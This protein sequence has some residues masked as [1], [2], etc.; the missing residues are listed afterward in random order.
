MSKRGRTKK[1]K[2]HIRST[3]EY[4]QAEENETAL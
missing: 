2:H 3:D 1:V 4:Q